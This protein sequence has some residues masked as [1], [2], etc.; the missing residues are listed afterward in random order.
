MQLQILSL[1]NYNNEVGIK[2][3]DLCCIVI[4]ENINL[5]P[6]CDQI[7]SIRRC[8]YDFICSIVFI[9]KIGDFQHWM[10]KLRLTKAVKKCQN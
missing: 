5:I 2:A 6:K 1:V 10:Q 9:A 8:A 4:C 7:F 3:N